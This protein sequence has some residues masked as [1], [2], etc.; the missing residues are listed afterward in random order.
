M[1]D[2]IY[3]N[4]LNPKHPTA[5]SSPGNIKRFNKS[6]G[7]K[8][9]LDTVNAI[10]TYTLHREFHKPRVRNPYFV[11]EKR[12]QVQA[13]LID[14]SGIKKDND[15]ITFLLVVIDVFT[16]LAWIEPLK[17]KTAE[18]TLGALKKIIIDMRKVPKSIL[19][20]RG[21]E[22]INK[23]VTEFLTN[24]NIRIIHPNS[25]IKAGVAERFNRTIQDLIYRYLTENETYRYINVLKDLLYAYNNRK[26]RTLKNI[27]P[28]QAELDEN[29]NLVLNAHNS[30]YSKIVE[31]RK[32]PK[33]QIGQ[34]VRIKS[35]TPF[36]QRG[37]HE[38][39]LREH[40][41]IIQIN[42]RMPIPM[43]I[44]QS[45]NTDDVITGA[46]YGEELQPVYGDVF[47]VEKVLK[48][49][50]LKS[51]EE[52]FFVK[53]QGYNENHNSWI[54]ATDVTKTYTNN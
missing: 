40:F 53:W 11:Y 41:K 47:K 8:A 27:T 9:I 14:V 24:N 26:H 50:K 3:N 39:F 49:R 1:N 51:G 37:Y 23:R 10:D 44:V 4:Y 21:K 35:L 19:F 36:F 18:A 7:R 30:N 32:T 16:K 38:R 5:F 29:K 2:E 46:F 43:Y 20:D 6:F 31:K 25:E 17:R 45:L 34:K 33:F 12:Q 13:D 42:K 52:E 28:A 54:K 15:D 22:F 48:K